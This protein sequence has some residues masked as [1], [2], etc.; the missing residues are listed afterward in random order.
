ML[1]AGL[2]RASHVGILVNRLFD[3]AITVCFKHKSGRDG[4]APS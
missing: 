1:L 2:A 4:V 3:P